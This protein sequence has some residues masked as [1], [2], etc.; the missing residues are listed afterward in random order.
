MTKHAYF[1]L[2]RFRRIIPW[3]IL[4]VCSLLYLVP[5]AV[6]DDVAETPEPLSTGDRNRR[7]MLTAGSGVGVVVVW[8][9]WQ[10]DYFSTSP[11]SGSEGW[12]GKNT[13]SG[14]ADKL[15]HAY[16]C[17][18]ASHGFSYL[19]E[20]WS[21]EK[22]DA[23]LFG[24]LT[25]LAVFGAMEL[26]DSFSDYGFSGEDMAANVVGCV[27]GYLLYTHPDLAGKIDLRWEI[28]P[29]PDQVDFTTDYENSKYLIALKL[30]GFEFARENWLKY[31][32]LHGG[33][34]TRDF[35]EAGASGK[36]YAYAGIGLNLTDLL[37]RNGYK[38][39]G[40]VLRY[41][42]LPYTSVTGGCEF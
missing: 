32:E 20:Y 17:Y 16:S 6:S 39:T 26:G 3:R 7:V 5:F 8:G 37:F 12:F 11:H 4:L 10:W 25:S 18:V 27:A 35:S 14:G 42:Q 40:T 41:I 24:S 21:F 2:F 38:K 22:E 29:S 9:V 33:Y 13:K 30:N 28:G 34:Y 36:R 19:Y 23:A 15:G 31:I 1:S